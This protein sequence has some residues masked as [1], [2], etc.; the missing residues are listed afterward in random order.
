MSDLVAR[1]L[2]VLWHP[3]THFSDQARLPPLPIAR[4]QGSWLTTTDGRRILDAIASW[5]TCVH[6]HGHPAIREAIRAQVEM[7]DHVMLAGFTHEPAVRLAETLLAH[8]P[9]DYGKVFYAD[10]GSAAVEVA[11]KMSFQSRLQR[12]EAG[13]RR[14]AA[15]HNSYHGETLGALSV[16]GNETYRDMFSPMLMDVLYLPVARHPLHRD[17]DLQD[18]SLGA[19]TPEADA[20]VAL[21]RAHANTLTGLVIEPLVQC[22]GKMSMMGIGYYERIVREAQ[23]LGIHVIA[24]EIAVAFGRTGKLF[25]TDWTS[26][27]PDMVCLSKGLS[28]GVLPLSCVLLKRGFE[29]DFHGDPG[30]SFL[31]S[32]TFTGNPIACAAGLA[33]LELLLTDVLP[34]LDAPR[35][36]FTAAVERVARESPE[37]R[38]HRQCGWIAAFDVAPSHREAGPPDGRLSLAIREAALARGVLLRPLHDTVYWMP[39]L[40]I[41]E[42]ELDHLA[43]T[44]IAVLH[45]VL[46]DRPTG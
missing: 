7:L 37:V 27:H 32:H 21:L 24:D 33:S 15:L 35:Q 19:Q 20:A 16:S 11:L 18:S 17:A 26:I 4:A 31:H 9:G 38:A 43:K 14:F 23:A 8:A 29:D 40:S 25:A 46:G 42:D 6:G 36:R 2:A 30:R 39:P 41:R 22:A 28:G 45:E 44:T 13:R 12:G 3:A 1:D 5:W 10:C 34:N